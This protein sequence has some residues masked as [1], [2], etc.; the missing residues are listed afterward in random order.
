MFPALYLLR[1]FSDDSFVDSFIVAGLFL[2]AVVTTLRRSREDTETCEPR[3]FNVLS[4]SIFFFKLGNDCIVDGLRSLTGCSGGTG[5]VG[6]CGA[7]C[8]LDRSPLRRRLVGA[9]TS[10][11]T[12]S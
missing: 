9:K 3:T 2:G 4:S 8:L 12:C 7:S 1:N 11:K 5:D 6:D 10:R